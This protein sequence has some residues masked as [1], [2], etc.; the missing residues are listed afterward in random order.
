MAITTALVEDSIIPSCVGE[1]HAR[2]I[3]IQ[4]TDLDAGSKCNEPIKNRI[5]TPCI[6]RVPR[7]G[8]ST[9]LQSFALPK[10]VVQHFDHEVHLVNAHNGYDDQLDIVPD[11]GA[12]ISCFKDKC[13]FVSFENLKPTVSVRVAHGASIQATAIGTVHLQVYADD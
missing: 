1:N 2:N 8:D 10:S 11:S 7:L 5:R 9:I 12:T 3:G 6:K 4:N 13:L